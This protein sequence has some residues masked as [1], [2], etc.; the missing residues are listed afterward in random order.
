MPPRGQRRREGPYV[1]GLGDGETVTRVSPM[2]T[3][4]PNKVRVGRHSQRQS[5]GGG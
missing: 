3:G 2:L 5:K 4:T 1:L